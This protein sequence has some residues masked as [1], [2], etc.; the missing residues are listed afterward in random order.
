V[1]AKG[2]LKE[3]KKWAGF[4]MQEAKIEGLW[5]GSPIYCTTVFQFVKKENLRTGGSKAN[6]Y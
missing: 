4:L 5:L 3:L 2:I 6:P 1:I